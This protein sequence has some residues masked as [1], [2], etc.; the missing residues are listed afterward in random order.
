MTDQV[1][2]DAIVQLIMDLFNEQHLE[3]QQATE[4]AI[5][6]LLN[7]VGITGAIGSANSPTHKVT[8]EAL[9]ETYETDNADNSNK[10]DGTVH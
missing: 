7:V 4:V 2:N 10:A 8:I 3:P 1:Q 6:T 5:S 9:E